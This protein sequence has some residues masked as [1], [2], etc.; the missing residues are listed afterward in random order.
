MTEEENSTVIPL[1]GELGEQDSA[2]TASCSVER[3]G[4]DIELTRRLAALVSAVGTGDQQAFTDFYRLTSHRVFGLAVRMLRNRSTAEEVT[5][6]VYLQ[7]WTLADRYD[8]R[9]SSPM[10]WLLMLTHRRAVDRIRAESAAVGRDTVYGQLHLARDHDVVL[11]QVQQ[12]F[13][14]RAVT[15]CLGRLTP[16]QRDTIVLAY[17]GGLTYSEVAE[18]LGTPVPTVKSRIRDGLKRLAAC[19]TGSDLL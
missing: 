19:L 1:F 6:E 17:Y 4:R 2:L 13:E 10:G 14:E 15:E 12:N 9:M 7:A 3:P 18:K 5:Q 11:E 8:E 16:L